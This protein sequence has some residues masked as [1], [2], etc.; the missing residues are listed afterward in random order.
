MKL[1]I[2]WIPGCCISTIYIVRRRSLRRFLGTL[3]NLMF[4]RTRLLSL[5]KRTRASKP[6][7]QAMCRRAF[8]T[9]LRIPSKN[10]LSARYN[11]LQMDERQPRTRSESGSKSGRRAV[12]ALTNIVCRPEK[13]TYKNHHQPQAHHI[14]E[15]NI[16]LI[17]WGNILFDIEGSKADIIIQAYRVSCFKC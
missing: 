16:I 4:P 15:T 1:G 17:T 3:R 6:G 7:A 2:N 8:L 13:L 10:A 5:R 11:S 9:S 14:T 12:I